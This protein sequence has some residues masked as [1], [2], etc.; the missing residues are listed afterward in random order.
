MANRCA[1]MQMTKS[2]KAAFAWG[3]EMAMHSGSVT[4]TLTNKSF[5]NECFINGELPINTAAE[6]FTDNCIVEDALLDSASNVMTCIN[7]RGGFNAIL[8]VKRGEVLDQGVDQPNNGLACNAA[9][10]E[11]ESSSLNHHIVRL[12]PAAPDAINTEDLNALKFN[13]VAGLQLQPQ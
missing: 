7:N 2:G 8:W 3:L 6:T 4:T 10:T 13:A 1:C 9:R 12:F 5:T 11:V